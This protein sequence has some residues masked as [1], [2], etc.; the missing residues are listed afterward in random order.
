MEPE[1]IEYEALKLPL[2]LRA[3]L[4]ERLLQ[5]L[6]GEHARSIKAWAHVSEKRM[7]MFHSGQMDAYPHQG[8]VD[9]LRER[10]RP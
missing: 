5:T 1:V 10:L 2:H 7:E 6:E 4:A 3:V 8:V 9:E